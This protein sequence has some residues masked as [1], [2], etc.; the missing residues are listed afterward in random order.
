[1]EHDA[2]GCAGG[3]DPAILLGYC[4]L[5]ICKVT[6]RPDSFQQIPCLHVAEVSHRSPIIAVAGVQEQ[7]ETMEL[8]W[9]LSGCFWGI[10]LSAA[11]LAVAVAGVSPGMFPV[12]R[13]G[14]EC[15]QL[16]T[17]CQKI[18]QHPPFSQFLAFKRVQGWDCS[19][20]MRLLWLSHEWVS[21]L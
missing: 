13:Q 5:P 1:M 9:P 2:A 6:S 21:L 4:S 15:A 7:Q 16:H 11:L 18:L 14:A 3:Q 17:C 20:L 12:P 10:L 19:K 8:K